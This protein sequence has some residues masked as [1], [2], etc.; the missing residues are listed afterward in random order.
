MMI[1][2]HR[3]NTREQLVQT[4]RQ[5]GVEIDLRSRGEDIILQHDPFKDGERLEE[6]LTAYGHRLVILN[7]KEEGLEERLLALMARAGIEEFFFLDQ[8]FPFLVRT[9]MS[10]EARCAIRISEYE[11]VEAALRLAGKVRWAWIDCFTR[12]PLSGKEARLL[13]DAGFRLCLVSPELQGRASAEEI[14]RM[15]SLL[16]AESID[17][18][19]VCTKAPERWL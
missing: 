7:T 11:P 19:A 17:V 5:Y 6:W 16:A 1:V 2:A 9:A 18:D 4:P 3:R 12:F 13:R 10:G 15:R 8:S 14:T